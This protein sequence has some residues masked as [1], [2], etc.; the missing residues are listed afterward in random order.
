VDIQTAI[1]GPSGLTPDRGSTEATE[2]AAAARRR[3]I[4]ALADVKEAIYE[5]RSWVIEAMKRDDLAEQFDLLNGIIGGL[6]KQV[7]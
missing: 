4:D 5:A 7:R 2:I 3:T 6:M 1:N